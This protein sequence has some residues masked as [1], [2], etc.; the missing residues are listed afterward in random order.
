MSV[1][2]VVAICNS[3]LTFKIKINKKLTLNGYR[4]LK[5]LY[6]IELTNCTAYIDFLT[7]VSYW[8]RIAYE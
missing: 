6:G 1:C 4:T 2:G 5:E 8:D 3:H 7:A